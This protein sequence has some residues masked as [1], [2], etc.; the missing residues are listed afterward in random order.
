MIIHRHL[1]RDRVRHQKRLREATIEPREQQR[2]QRTLK[3]VRAQTGTRALADQKVVI[4]GA[5]IAGLTCGYELA[6]LGVDV[7]L[8]EAEPTH[9]GGRVRT[10]RPGGGLYAELG[11]MRIP[12]SHN[13]TNGYISEFSLSTRPFLMSNDNAFSFIRKTPFK[14]GDI[15]GDNE[16]LAMGLFN[17]S[18]PEVAMGYG[19]MWE[20]AV[21]DV[22]DGLTDPQVD[23]LYADDMTD[24]TVIGLDHKALA[25]ALRD[26]GLSREASEYVMTMMGL[27]TALPIALTEHL[28]EEN[29]AV[30]LGNFHEI[31]GGTD[32][33]ATAFRDALNAIQPGKI[34]QGCEVLRI[35][36]SGAKARAIY[37]D[38]T[39]TYTEE[40]DWV[41]CTIP[42]GVLNRL[43]IHDAFSNQRLRAIQ[44]VNYDPS[45]KV[46]GRSPNRW[47][48][49]VDGIYGGGSMY[50]TQMGS[51]WY[52]ADNTAQDANVT[53]AESLFLASYTWGQ[54]ARRIATVPDDQLDD[55]MRQELGRI[56]TSIESTPN[57]YSTE[58]RWAWD[59][60][61]TQ[62][63]AYAFF[64][65]GEQYRFYQD[66]VGPDGRIFL[67]GEH[68]SHTHSWIQ[69]ALE[70]AI[71]TIDEITTAVGS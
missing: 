61:P 28:R 43:D 48:E 66:M 58:I 13:L 68:V 35:E 36:Q 52:P 64:M 31:V 39:N 24:P 33:L 42:F 51:T 18:P 69:G 23:Q 60:V 70:S 8:L 22:L 55:V 14:V 47:W 37:S 62:S 45:T 3:S 26:A 63:G 41:I 67:T 20:A 44:G 59:Q 29:D 38:G 50:D 53:N 49:S 16:V 1:L 27:E 7:V 12:E 56:H 5:G 10:H 4:L 46:I 71:R 6:Q 19:G 9:V 32:L 65:P 40:G 2:L 54:L 30:W 15:A 11:A 21:L 34:K 25:T 57:L 17:L